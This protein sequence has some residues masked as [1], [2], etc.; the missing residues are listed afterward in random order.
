MIIM[1]ETENLKEIVVTGLGM[2]RFLK[3]H[4]VQHVFGIPDGHTLAKSGGSCP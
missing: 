3:E 2:A 1:T 4:G